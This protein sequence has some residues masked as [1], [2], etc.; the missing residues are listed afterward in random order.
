MIDQSQL[1]VLYWWSHIVPFCDA[2]TFQAPFG[3]HEEKTAQCAPIQ[4][5]DYL[6]CDAVTHIVNQV[7]SI[8]TVVLLK[9]LEYRLSRVFNFHKLYER[10]RTQPVIGHNLLEVTI[11]KNSGSKYNWQLWDKT[12]SS[13]KRGGLE[14]I[15]ENHLVSLTN[16][17]VFTFLIQ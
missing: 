2:F 15:Q 11:E 17:D 5:T 12:F 10:L 7:S 4:D 3:L 9:L 6:S 8:Q 16:E 13:Q 14:V 1:T